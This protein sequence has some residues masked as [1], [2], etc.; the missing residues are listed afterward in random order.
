M[1]KLTDYDYHLPESLISHSPEEKRDTSRLMHINRQ[2]GSISHNHFSDLPDYLTSSDILVVNNTKV[3][4][5]RLNGL[6]KTGGKVEVLIIDYTGGID[7]LKKTGHFEC[8]CLIRASKRPKDGSIITFEND[9]SA[10]VIS[11]T[12]GIYRVRFS[13]K[14]DFDES[15]EKTG[16]MPLPPYISRKDVPPCDDKVTYQTVYAAEKGAVAAPTAGLHFT[17]EL[18]EKIRSKGVQIVTITLHVGYGTFVPVRVEDIRDHDI[19]TE[20]YY[21]SRES[22]DLLN[23]AGENGKRIIAV[24]TTTVRTLEYAMQQHGEIKPGS[25]DCDLFIYP[26]YEFKMIDAM[27]TNFHIPKSTLLMLVS[28]FAG[29]EMIFIA[30]QTAIDNKYRFYS[31]GDSMLIT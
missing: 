18:L 29:K 16:I 13:S 31:Y 6:K 22:A 7:K 21:I 17:D 28:A 4:P 24:G 14:T 3:I 5:A 19:H 1:Y 30:Y 8:E 12:D 15:L 25:G 2:K 9:L 27:V 11:F 10:T 23:T 20:K 26:G